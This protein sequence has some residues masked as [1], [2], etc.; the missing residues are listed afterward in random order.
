MRK[1]SSDQKIVEESKGEIVIVWIIGISIA[2]YD[3]IEGRRSFHPAHCE[4]IG[5]GVPVGPPDGLDGTLEDFNEEKTFLCRELWKMELRM[6]GTWSSFP[7]RGSSHRF[8]PE[9]F[10]VFAGG[11]K[12]SRKSFSSRRG[13]SRSAPAS[14]SSSAMFIMTR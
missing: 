12:T 7:G 4:M 14:R 1:G 9:A 6:V 3:G 10:W 8:L 2:E 5:H 13:S 11:A